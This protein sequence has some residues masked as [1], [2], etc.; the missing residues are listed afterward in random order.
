MLYSAQIEICSFNRKPNGTRERRAVLEKY[1]E[2]AT[3]LHSAVIRLT[4]CNRKITSLKVPRGRWVEN[5]Y[6]CRKD[7]I[8][9]LS[10]CNRGSVHWVEKKEGLRGRRSSSP[11]TVR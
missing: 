9:H 8:C 4:E 1:S 6:E 7:S 2:G 3:G 10:F 5:P 11:T